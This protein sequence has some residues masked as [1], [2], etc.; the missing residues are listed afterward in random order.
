MSYKVFYNRGTDSDFFN[1]CRPIAGAP[2]STIYRC[3][4]AS[5]GNSSICNELCTNVYP[6]TIIEDCSAKYG[7]WDNGHFN[8]NCVA[9][10]SENIQSCCFTKCQKGQFTESPNI[11]QEKIPN[12]QAIDCRDYCSGYTVI[13]G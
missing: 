10:N 3:C 5:C 12:T 13:N 7:C 6:G 2:L 1:S 4:M 8:T 9:Q 11:K